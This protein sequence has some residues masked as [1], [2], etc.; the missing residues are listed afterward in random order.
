M[1]KLFSKPWIVDLLVILL[2]SLTPLLWF[3]QGQVMVGHDN[4]APLVPQV[5]LSGRLSTWIN[6]FFGQSQALILGTIPIHFLDALPSFLGFSLETSQKIVYVL[7]FFLIGLSAYILASVINGKSHIF[8]LIATTFY[9]FNF[10]ILQGWWIGEKSKFSAY[11]A[12]PLV[13][14]LFI[15][16]YNARL[17][18]LAGS[19]LVGLTLF[20]FNAGGL[21]GIP[22]YGGLMV[23][24]F[25]FLILICIRSLVQKD[26]KPVRRII[27]LVG[28]GG[29]A[30]ILANAYFFLPAY[31][32]LKTSLVPG[33]NVIGGTSGVVDWANEI[34]ANTS[35]LNLMRLEGIPEWYDN[36][37]HP[38]AKQYLTNPILVG[39][40]FLFPILVFA[41]LLVVKKRE[42]R[43][44]VIVFFSIY[45]VG[46]QFSA[47]THPPLGFI[48]QFFVEKIPGFFIFRTPYFKFA[49]ALYL[50]QAILAAFTLDNLPSRWR[51]G[52]FIIVVIGLLFYH[53]PFFKGNFFDWRQ[54][55]STRLAV[56][57]Y[58]Y[59]FGRW[60]EE[61]RD[62]RVLMLPPNSPSFRYS[63]YRWGYLSFQALPTLVSN[64]SVVINNDK[65]DESERDVVESMYRAIVA[66]DR[67]GIDRYIS[68]LGLTHVV[69]EH[70]TAT[71]IESILPLTP[72]PYEQGLK[73]SG[74]FTKTNQF[75]QWDLYAIDGANPSIL[76]FVRSPKLI[77]A[78]Q[79]SVDAFIDHL[80]EPVVFIDD[81]SQ[82][83]FQQP[84]LIVAECANCPKKGR[85]IVTFPDR[86]VLSDDPFYPLLTFFDRFRKV[87]SDPKS[88]IYSYL[89]ETLKQISEVNETILQQK[90]IPE[91]LVRRYI[92]TLDAIV[93]N[94]AYLPTLKEKI[95][96]AGDVSQYLREERNFL[97]PN[98]GRYVTG[99]TQTILVGSIFSGIRKT[100]MALESYIAP[101]GDEQ[102]RL[103]QLSVGIPSAYQVY[104]RS[105]DLGQFIDEGRTSIEMTIDQEQMSR[106]QTR[107]DLQKTR[108]VPFGMIT[109]ASGY[110]VLRFQLPEVTGEMIPLVPVET[111]FSVKGEN[112]CFGN[113]VGGITG[114]SLYQFT[115]NYTN[116]FSD[117]L[118]LFIWEKDGDSKQLSVAARLPAS[119]LREK[120]REAF[121]V[122]ETTKETVIAVCAPNINQERAA[123]NIQTSFT[124]LIYP[125]VVLVP[126]SYEGTQST[127]LEMQR[128][129]PARFEATLP[130]E[131]GTRLLVV[132]ERFDPW[133]E[134]TGVA[135]KHVRVNGYANG[136]FID[137]PQGQTVTIAYR[138]DVFFR[139][140]IAV[141]TGAV[142]VSIFFL[143][144]QRRKFYV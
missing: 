132:S 137:N 76:S 49:P 125:T 43:A 24:L 62:A 45:L 40:S 142:G 115:V 1:K 27:A 106:I 79:S 110:H 39:A 86:P 60:L 93:T 123:E 61:H 9:Q 92:K 100:E 38:F 108:W 84:T 83:Q 2:L 112:V 31:T 129:S 57:E 144:R 113:T 19:I 37:N 121:E 90:S 64:G 21:Y 42:F 122:S 119:T 107:I 4:V 140:G 14:A 69:L 101:Y 88:A 29:I 67:E 109:L 103:Y 17:S 13:L 7:W 18:P 47:G 114:R 89:G 25:C 136:W 54:G 141:S 120:V 35:F 53:A 85:P 26:W 59:S 58:V 20:L 80:S 46:M 128:K 116:D 117:N 98:L 30:I 23:V 133:W 82:L 6:H 127:S 124:K 131:D 8:K 12:Q 81:A 55:Y 44:Y 126:Q 10:F 138:G 97:R 70:D 111:E 66:R 78:K 73:A 105:A 94:F 130:T 51:R 16:V 68:L 71:D 87:P 33:V 65:L 63:L 56:P 5:F 96:V 74:R 135:A 11:I 104:V 118:L 32:R 102:T 139:W 72:Q 22:L 75:G 15:L 77:D 41:S 143:W 95:L 99:G 34:S 50:A 91:T 48:Y 36:P 28:G 52:V 134:L 3:R